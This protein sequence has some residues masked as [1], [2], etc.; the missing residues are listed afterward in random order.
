MVVLMFGL[1]VVRRAERLYN[2]LDRRRS[3]QNRKMA[4][5]RKRGEDRKEENL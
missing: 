3:D 2:T 4:K 1:I 5:S